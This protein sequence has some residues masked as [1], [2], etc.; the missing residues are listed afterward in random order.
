MSPPSRP[1][2]RRALVWALRLG[3]T[4]AGVAYTL[5]L[6]DLHQLGWA[7]RQIPIGAFAVAVA[8]V[9][10]NVLAGALRWRVLLTA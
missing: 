7:F 9:G 2:L 10:L 3:G 4:A 8:L 6:V 1:G 5:A